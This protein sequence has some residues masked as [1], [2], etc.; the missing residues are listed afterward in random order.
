M[1]EQSP[2]P[3]LNPWI[4]FICSALTALGILD[5]IYAPPT[6]F[7]VVVRWVGVL[8]LACL[9]LHIWYEFRKVRPPDS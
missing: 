6:A 1:P 9:V 2:N 5:N 7:H 8:A 3:Q 4:V